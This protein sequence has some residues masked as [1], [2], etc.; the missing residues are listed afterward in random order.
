MDVSIGHSF[1]QRPI[2]G[3]GAIVKTASPVSR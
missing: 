2:K 1:A 3:T